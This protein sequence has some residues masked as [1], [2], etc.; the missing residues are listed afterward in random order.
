MRLI[1]ASRSTLAG[2]IVRADLQEL[3]LELFVLGDIDRMY[4]VGQAQLLEHDGS[5][6]AV[7]GGPGI[8]IDHGFLSCVCDLVWL[9]CVTSRG[10]T[11]A[12]RA[13]SPPGK[14]YSLLHHEGMGEG[15]GSFS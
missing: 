3:R 14:G 9:Y 6:A 2:M 5:F 4:A 11:I 8:E 10:R 13:L 7:G 12:A 1:P 15:V